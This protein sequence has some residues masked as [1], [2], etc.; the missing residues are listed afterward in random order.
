M[1][2]VLGSSAAVLAP[3]AISS[4]DR[5]AVQRDATGVRNLDERPQPDHRRYRKGNGL[6]SKSALA[7]LDQ[8][9]L[10]PEH[11]HNG[12]A[13]RND[14]QRLVSGVEYQG[15]CHAFIESTSPILQVGL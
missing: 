3:A 10:L 2:E 4:E 14:R 8:F 13:C 6:R 7:V 12:T 5:P 15:T 9:R 1:I 11:E